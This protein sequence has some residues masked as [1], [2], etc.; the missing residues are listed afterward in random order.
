MIRK[1][2]WRF[3]YK[4]CFLLYIFSFQTTKHYS[5][6]LTIDEL[7]TCKIYH[8]LS[9]ALKS[10]EKVY[11]LELSKEK[12][13]TFPNEILNLKNLQ[14]LDL[15]KNKLDSI[16]DNIKNLSSLQYLNIGKNNLTTFPNGITKLEN[17][18]SLILN[19]NNITSIPDNVDE[20]YNLEYLDMWSNNLEYISEN[21][22]FLTQLKELDLRVIIFNNDEKERIKSLLP[23]AKVYF[24]NSCNCG[25]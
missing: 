22:K 3:F 11:V 6:L 16:P 10:T 15:Y 4:I 18:K 24:S 9:E 12:L 8:S 2:H 14:K 1:P 19:Q 7:D 13:K 23:G 20:L 5:Q 21:I 17:L 25:Y